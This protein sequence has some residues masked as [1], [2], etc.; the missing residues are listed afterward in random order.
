MQG[1][2]QKENS[3]QAP[4][5]T[6]SSHPSLGIA[7]QSARRDFARG[8]KVAG[9]VDRGERTFD[10]LTEEEQELHQKYHTGELERRR[11]EC[12]AA[13]GHG[14]GTSQKISINSYAKVEGAIRV[15]KSSD[16]IAVSQYQSF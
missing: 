1:K 8:E 6:W 11:K 15:L 13:W 2:T 4:P 7:A 3:R 14:A 10:L 9:A 12:R 5:H 16:S